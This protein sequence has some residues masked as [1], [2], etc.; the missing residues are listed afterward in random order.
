MK[1]LENK[2]ID[3]VVSEKI[4]EIKNDKWIVLRYWEIANVACCKLEWEYSELRNDAHNNTHL[5]TCEMIISNDNIY[6]IKKDPYKILWLKHPGNLSENNLWEHIFIQSVMKQ[7]IEWSSINFNKKRI[8]ESCWNIFKLEK[9][10]NQ[11]V[12]YFLWNDVKIYIN[13]SFNAV[14]AYQSLIKLV[15]KEV[16]E[17][18]KN[19][20]SNLNDD[21]QEFLWRINDF[22]DRCYNKIDTMEK[23]FN[24]ENPIIESN[25]DTHKLFMANWAILDSENTIE[26]W[27]NLLDEF[28]NFD[29]NDN[30]INQYYW[31]FKLTLESLEETYKKVKAKYG[32][33]I[34]TYKTLRKITSKNAVYKPRKSIESSQDSE[35][36]SADSTATA[37]I[38]IVLIIIW[39]IILVAINS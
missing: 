21:F 35:D 34:S 10:E 7:Y 28:N 26:K 19:I 5:W 18:N 23:E 15:P 37:T 11:F 17:H 3:K 6:Y 25:T 1:D 24:L 8:C 36:D 32:P 33:A 29:L 22:Q 39:I 14:D 20:N 4:K 12:L 9:G 38:W 27:Y 31:F 2:F 16:I 30:D 13:N